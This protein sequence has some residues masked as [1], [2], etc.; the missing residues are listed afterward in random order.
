[1]TL[2]KSMNALAGRLIPAYGFQSVIRR[3]SGAVDPVTGTDSRSTVNLSV[4]AV[5]V[6]VEQS[7]IDGTLIQSGDRMYV[8]T[9][10]VEPRNGDLF[11]VGADFWSVVRV[12][13]SQVQ[14]GNVAY[15]IQVRA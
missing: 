8:L 11:Q 5:A 15:R 2:R 1:M 4:N 13:P 6:N 12:M 9:S 14:D 7:Q 10:D 3:H